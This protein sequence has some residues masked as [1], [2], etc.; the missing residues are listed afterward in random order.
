M[1]IYRGV[2][3]V[4]A[5]PKL[6]PRDQGF[7]Y[8]TGLAANEVEVTPQDA[9]EAVR[10]VGFTEYG[11]AIKRLDRLVAISNEAELAAFD[12][13]VKSRD[14]HEVYINLSRRAVSHPSSLDENPELAG[15]N[16]AR[17]G[18]AWIMA[19]A[20]VEYASILAAYTGVSRPYESV[21]GSGY[22]ADQYREMLLDALRT[23]YWALASDA[24]LK[25][26]AREFKPDQ[27]S[28]A[29]VRR[30]TL[31]QSLFGAAIKVGVR[32]YTAVQL[33]EL[34]VWKT[35]L[36]R[37]QSRLVGNMQAFFYRQQKDRLSREIASMC[38]N[39]CKRLDERTTGDA[40]GG[41]LKNAQNAR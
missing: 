13:I 15:D 4:S 23:H 5:K 8:K 1:F 41:S 2:P 26:V 27:T 36:D 14:E 12:E 25:D 21:A 11:Q 18:L 35:A 30:M 20:R 29:Y 28:L 40:T 33:A 32:D 9:R 16:Y 39:A 31:V 19:L 38:Q 22:D 6:S 37:I 7:A 34:R 3:S 17:R 24:R 10:V